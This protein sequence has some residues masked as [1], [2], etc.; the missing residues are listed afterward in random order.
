[1]T[2]HGRHLRLRALVREI[3][4]EQIGINAVAGQT[5]SHGTV[6]ADFD[7]GRVARIYIPRVTTALHGRRN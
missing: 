6:S 5:I 7:F 3:T 1:M 2:A 4:I